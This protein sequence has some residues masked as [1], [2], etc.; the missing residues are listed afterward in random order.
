MV[1]DSGNLKEVVSEKHR[2]CCRPERAGIQTRLESWYQESQIYVVFT[3]L[4]CS[5]SSILLSS[6][7]ASCSGLLVIV[8][9]REGVMF[10]ILVTSEGSEML[11]PEGC[12]V[13]VVVVC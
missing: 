7:A 2:S 8:S 3:G 11:G 10:G 9:G 12:W 4:V 6:S 5:L 1:D 13:A